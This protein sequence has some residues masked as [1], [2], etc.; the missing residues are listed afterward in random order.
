VNAVSRFRAMGCEVVLGGADA[1]ET[2]AVA[3]LFEAHDRTFSRFR[4]DSELNHVNRSREP[5]VRVSA[6][7]AAAVAAALMAAEETGGLVDP[8]LHD[9]LVA[10]GYDRDFGSLADDG[11]AVG[12]AAPGRADRV[13]LVGRL[14]VRPPGLRLDLNGVVKAMAV[15][16][17]LALTRTAEFV[18]AG[19]DLATHSGVDVALPGGGSVRLERGGLATSGSDVRTWKRGGV[20]Q[21]HLIDPRSGRP[22]DSPWSQVTVCGA[23]CLAADVAAK[24]AFLLG[25][26][27]PAWL[28]ERSLPG[29]FVR[30]DGSVVGNDHWRAQTERPLPCT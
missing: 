10:A 13:R 19:G 8:T 23:D 29:R 20:P 3:E 24:A 21:H 12:A 18:S 14:L 7:F 17:A 27:G 6:P 1:A 15:D 2:R 28:A 11:R 5:A 26:A 9:A 22:A 16:A 4:A 25:E 30:P